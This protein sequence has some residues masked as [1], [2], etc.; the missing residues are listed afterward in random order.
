MPSIGSR[1]LVK[2]NDL[3]NYRSLLEKLRNTTNPNA[4]YMDIHLDLYKVSWKIVDIA[5]DPIFG[6]VYMC[7]PVSKHGNFKQM[8]WET[9]LDEI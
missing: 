4:T 9:D 3:I 7:S 2:H 1:V 5:Q 6:T 8:F